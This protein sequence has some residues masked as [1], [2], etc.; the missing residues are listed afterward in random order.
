MVRVQQTLKREEGQ[1]RI[2]AA[3]LKYGRYVDLRACRGKQK[4]HFRQVRMVMAQARDAEL[5]ED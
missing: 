1:A 5:I 2:L 4:A 3:Q